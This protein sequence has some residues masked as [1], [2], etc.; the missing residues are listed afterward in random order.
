MCFFCFFVFFSTG[1]VCM[2]SSSSVVELVMLLCS[3]A[4]LA[5]IFVNYPSFLCFSSDLIYFRFTLSAV[6]PQLWVDSALHHALFPLNSIPST[7]PHQETGEKASPAANIGLRVKGGRPA[8][9]T[10]D[11]SA[12]SC[13]LAEL[14]R[15]DNSDLMV[16]CIDYPSRLRCLASV[17]LP[18]L[19]SCCQ[20]HEY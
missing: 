7:F 11:P 6:N 10:S 15:R 5:S 13:G 16:L 17:L 4:S 14:M 3:Q 19:F 20:I 1:L 9:V 12:G 18:S 2:K 8:C